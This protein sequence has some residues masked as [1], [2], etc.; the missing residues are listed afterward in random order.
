MAATMH[1]ESLEAAGL[2]PGR[3]ERRV[4]KA[5]RVL[6]LRA[7]PGPDGGF[8]STFTDVTEF[9]AAAQE[10]QRAKAAAEAANLAKSRFL[11]TMSHELRTPLNAVIGFSDALVRGADQDGSGQ[12]IEF[13]QA[14]N[15]AGR[16]LLTLVNNILDVARIDAGRFDLSSE[17]VD[18]G[19]LIE[20]CARQIDP[21]A[22][23]AEVALSWTLPPELPVLRADERRF[24]Q[25]LTQLL[26]NAV[27]FTP[28]GGAV[29]VAAT[30]EADGALA[31]RVAD[32]GIGIAEPDLQRV[33]EPFGQID[34]SLARPFPGSGLGLYIARALV[35]AH[36]G[37]LLLRSTLGTGTVAEL[38]LPADRL[39]P[40]GSAISSD[41]RENT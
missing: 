11:A 25:V 33:F 35:H 3:V 20:V 21:V 12:V 8:V 15:E 17:W 40:R 39:A 37:Q 23:A 1:D 29:T 34:E 41:P 14:I 10:L 31:I 4:T 27:K 24:R 32:T 36:G 38:R 16:Q 26:S 2:R 9:Y 18:L 5:G 28:A 19:R 30:Q 22:Q 7:D 13:A 6:E